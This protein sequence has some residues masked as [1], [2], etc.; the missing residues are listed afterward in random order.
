MRFVLSLIP[1]VLYMA[2]ALAQSTTFYDKH[3]NREGS[4]SRE[5]YRDVMR[6][7][8]GNRESYYEKQGNETVHRDKN[9]NRLGS[10]R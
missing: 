4:V 3:G 1:W 2:P 6:D 10:S 9:G 5:G 7:K 8:N